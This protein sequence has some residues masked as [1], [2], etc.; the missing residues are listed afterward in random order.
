MSIGA[1]I[2]AAGKGSRMGNPKWRLTM[3]NGEY[4]Y[5]YLNNTYKRLGC[6]TVTVVNNDD[7]E[8][9]KSEIDS[10]NINIT[11][12]NR[13]DY[14]RLYSL[15]CG[16]KS[17][18]DSKHYLVHNID[19]P[20]ISKDLLSI[21]ISAVSDYDFALPEYGGRGGHPL[22][23]KNKVAERIIQCNEPYPDIR[24]VLSSSGATEYLIKIQTY[25]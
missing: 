6:E 4:F 20:F 7:Y 21:L 15:Q 11:K 19:N 2:L 17:L 10:S 9:I 18:S 22:L 8:A 16:L 12:N 1:V 25:Y 14:G 13:L 23:I 5:Q 24:D 3:P